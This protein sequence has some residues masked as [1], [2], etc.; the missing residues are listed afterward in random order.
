MM[1]LAQTHVDLARR[2]DLQTRK[3]IVLT[4]WVIAL[5][6]MMTITGAAMI[7]VLASG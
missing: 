1:R 5:S 4:R 3:T 2:L 6:I 7:A